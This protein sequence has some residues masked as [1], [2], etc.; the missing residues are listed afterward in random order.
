M[1]TVKYIPEGCKGENPKFSGSVE[2]SPISFDQKFEYLET[3]GI[4]VDDDGAVV[5]GKTGQKL[6]AVRQLV[7]ASEKHYVSVSLK[8]LSSGEEI[9]SFEQMSHD[10]E[11]HLMLIEIANYVIGGIKP[12]ND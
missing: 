6:K 9:T 3:L 11:C 2:L 1:K 5:T 8:K 10:D 7:K 12:G 4:D